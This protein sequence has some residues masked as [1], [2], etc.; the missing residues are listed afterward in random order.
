MLDINLN[1]FF[2]LGHCQ[3]EKTDSEVRLRAKHF[4]FNSRSKIQYSRPLTVRVLTNF[5]IAPHL[6]ECREKTRQMKQLEG[7]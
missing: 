3:L 2:I 7:E 6:Q 5:T 1:V 4:L